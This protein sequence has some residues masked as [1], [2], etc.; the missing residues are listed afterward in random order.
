MA[1]IV[2]SVSPVLERPSGYEGD[3]L[4]V[5]DPRHLTGELLH[6]YRMRYSVT[7]QLWALAFHWVRSK[8]LPLQVTLNKII[9]IIIYNL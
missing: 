1:N 9:S 3:V 7:G 6:Q 2:G 4:I 5:N 8:R